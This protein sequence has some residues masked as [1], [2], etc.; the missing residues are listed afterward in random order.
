MKASGRARS[1]S[2]V[3]SPELRE[4][5]HSRCIPAALEMTGPWVRGRGARRRQSGVV[6]E[7]LAYPCPPL[8]AGRGFRA[9]GPA[10]GQAGPPDSRCTGSPAGAWGAPT[11]CPAALEMNGPACAAGK[12]G[13]GPFRPVRGSIAPCLLDG[14]LGRGSACTDKGGRERE[15]RKH[16]LCACVVCVCCVRVRSCACMCSHRC[17]MHCSLFYGPSDDYGPSVSTPPSASAE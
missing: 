16:V 15:R 2:T 1:R 12:R 8:E 7:G 6:V 13:R 3:A 17:F 11:R 9:W 4:P 5:V 10:R 14:D